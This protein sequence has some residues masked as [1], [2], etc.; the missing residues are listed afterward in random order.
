MLRVLKGDMLGCSEG[1]LDTL[2]IDDGCDEGR[3]FAEAFG[4]PDVEGL[5]DGCELG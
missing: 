5:T 2:G 3:S 4:L 1:P